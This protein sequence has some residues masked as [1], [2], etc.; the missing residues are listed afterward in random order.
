MQLY[1]CFPVK[2]Y[3]ET[4]NLEWDLALDFYSFLI[5]LRSC[6][7]TIDFALRT[8]WPV[9]LFPS[10]CLTDINECAV[11]NGFCDKQRSTCQNMRGGHR[12]RCKEGYIL[13][14]NRRTCSG[15]IC[16]VLTFEEFRS[17]PTS[18]LF[19]FGKRARSQAKSQPCMLVNKFIQVAIYMDH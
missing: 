1:I 11:N 3:K 19:F 8:V 14:S 7:L 10:L 13:D 2:R 18:S 4:T 15:K 17:H 5:S 9:C 12:C 16:F 6:N